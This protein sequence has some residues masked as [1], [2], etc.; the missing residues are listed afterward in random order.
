MLCGLGMRLVTTVC[1]CTQADILFQEKDVC[2]Y[3]RHPFS[4]KGCLC[5]NNVHMG[6]I[7][8]CDPTNEYETILS[9]SELKF[10]RDRQFF[11]PANICSENCCDIL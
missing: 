6:R 10:H 5:T 11:V 1:S 4:R 2:V 3:V 9:V 7:I 8:V